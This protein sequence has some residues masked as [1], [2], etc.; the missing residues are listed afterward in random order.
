[1]FQAVFAWSEAPIGWIEAGIAW[2]STAVGGALPDGFIRSLF[3]DGLIAW[4]RR[5]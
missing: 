4:R 2:L 1:M 3:V 5:G